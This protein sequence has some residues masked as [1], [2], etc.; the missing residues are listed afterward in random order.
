M[1]IIMIALSFQYSTFCQS[2]LFQYSQNGK[3]T[4][5]QIDID[6]KLY[7]INGDS[8]VCKGKLVEYIISTNETA[9]WSNGVIAAKTSFIITGDTTIKAVVTNKYGCEYEQVK[10]IKAVDLP[11]KPIIIRNGNNL[12][13]SN[14]TGNF[15]W[16]RNNQ[17][18]AVGLSSINTTLEGNYTAKV[19][20]ANGCENISDPFNFVLSLNLSVNPSTLSVNASAGNTSFTI[21]S[22]TNWSINTNNTSWITVTPLSGSNNST[23]SISYQENSNAQSRSANIIV[24]GTGVTSQTVEIV[25]AGTSGSTPPWTAMPT[26]DNHTIIIP[27][28]IMSDINGT[29]LRNGDYIGV[30]YSNGG[31]L[32][33]SNFIKWEGSA[34]SIAAFGN[35]TIPPGKNGFSTNELFQFKLWRSSESKEYTINAR[36]ENPPQFPRDAIDKW[37]K[38]GISM[39]TS[40]KSSNRV[41]QN[42]TLRPSWNLISS[43]VIPENPNI[44]DVLSTI[45]NKVILIKDE[46]GTSA[47]P[48]QGYNNLGNWD[49]KKGYQIKVTEATTLSISGTRAEPQN[50]SLSFS[51]SWQII[52]YLCDNGNTPKSQFS[53][54]DSLIAQIKDQN[55]SSYIPS[56]GLDQLKCLK[57]GFGYQIRGLRNASFKY[58][59]QG[60]CTPLK[61]EVLYSRSSEAPYNNEVVNTG[62][63]A[64]IIFDKKICDIHL[65][66]GDIIYAFNGNELLSGKWKFYNGPFAMPVW[67]DDAY[68]ED[69]VDGLEDFEQMNFRIKSADGKIYPVDIE[70]KDGDNKYIKDGIYLV[71]SLRKRDKP[72]FQQIN[73]YPNPASDLMYLQY[74]ADENPGLVEIFIMDISGRLI[75]KISL[76]NVKLTEYGR[77]SIPISELSSGVY[78]FNI[79][80]DGVEVNKKVIITH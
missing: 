38:N 26:G 37:I 65:R 61:D 34:T 50:N 16:Y 6:K 74:L 29:A 63:N 31:Q 14:V 80:I 13:V 32:I 54:V 76:R 48:S 33:C 2:A 53:A 68:T 71:S 17:L 9:K 55:G 5:K 62:N 15:E 69:I 60:N 25:Q 75:N 43:Y 19:I 57:P 22:N 70:F 20:N 36:F 66:P 45:G 52:S 12:S 79:K 39:I 24:S 40:L 78:Q 4:H 58:N 18:F 7:K 41:T 77:F 44:L 27:S 72:D 56:Q 30:F 46:K 51:T 28:N 73:L 3:L 8:I 21:T 47:S 11:V 35:D 59:C 10:S 42:I 64:T 49:V 1:L 67:G 23:I